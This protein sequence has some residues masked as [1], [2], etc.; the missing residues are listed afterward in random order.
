MARFKEYGNEQNMLLPVSLKDQLIPGTFEYASCQVIDTL[1]LKSFLAKYHNDE[2]GA[3]AYD[4]RLLLK[5]IINSYAK[6]V[7]SSR[8]MEDLC[9]A[10]VL[11]IAITGDQAP[12][13]TTIATF[14]SSMEN[15][16]LEVFQ[17]VL[18]ICAQLDLIG[19]E[20]FALDGCKLSSNAAKES[21]G[22]IKEMERKKEKLEK[23]VAYLVERHKQTDRHDK[24]SRKRL[25]G[26]KDRLNKKID[27]IKKFLDKNDPKPGTR[28]GENKS[29]I[30]DNESAKMATCH[31]AIQGYNGIALA[32]AKHQIVVSA[33]AF[34][35]G[36]ENEFL[37]DMVE[38]AKEN[39]KRLKR[40]GLGVKKAALLADTNYFSESNCRYAL[41]QGINAYIPDSG[42]RTRDPR[43]PEN[44]D[45][46]RQKS[47]Y[48]QEDFM[49]F[50]LGDYF[51]CPT[52]KR[53]S[54]K[55]KNVFLRGYRG[56]RYEASVTDCRSCM[57]H[58]RCVR[59]GNSFKSLFI[60]TKPKKKTWSVK[61]T[62]KIDTV[63][64][65]DMYAKRMGIVEPV[66]A[67]ITF[68]KKLNRFTLRTRAKVRIQWLLYML[69][70]NIEKIGKYGDL[71]LIKGVS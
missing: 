37:D 25:R 13:H 22:T 54:L 31:G 20:I 34:G 39:F 59:Q 36:S 67:N 19:G 49:Y 47:K 56:K 60:T 18:L 8:G 2:R 23:T 41:A 69:V 71:R 24:E 16:I 32:D 63:E 27:R 14:I 40:Y 21:S 26:Q 17:Q 12:D 55:K 38:A 51:L 4:P 11:F 70:Q 65:R 61:M 7:N 64:G 44:R 50:A 46:H 48:Q 30:T 6:G 15:E 28:G 52:G 43:Y 35:S 53:L 5:I 62:E 9:H 1:D 10:N 68:H 57:K 42:F 33:D 45:S 66:F 3:A 29:N 58:H